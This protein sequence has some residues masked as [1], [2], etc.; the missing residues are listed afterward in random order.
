[1]RK[2]KEIWG[3]VIQ[4][5]ENRLSRAEIE[6]WFSNARL[7]EAGPSM[8]TIEVPNKFVANWLREKY[9]SELQ[10]G[11]RI[12]FEPPPEI[13][14]SFDVNP[15]QKSNFSAF[16]SG[17]GKT[18]L[19]WFD[20]NL[21]FESFITGETNRFAY[22]SALEAARM[23]G[24]HYNPLYIWGGPG[25]GKTHLLHA[26]GNYVQINR[27]PERAQY[28]TADHF[29]SL[30]SSARRKRTM[31]HLRKEINRVS[32]LLF[33]DVD[34]LAGRLKT[35]KEL[36]SFFNLFHETNRQIVFTAKL[37]PNQ[38][39]N[40]TEEIAS[41]LHWGVISEI[42]SPDQETKLKIIE[43]KCH[44]EGIDI[45]DDAAFFL[46]SNSS[47][48]KEL[49]R[50]V[51]R[52]HTYSSLHHKPI[53]ISLVNLVISG[54][55]ILSP[56]PNIKKIQE[57]TARFFDLPVSDLLSGSKK[58]QYS[59]PRQIAMYLC[60]RYTDCSYKE[61]GT[62]FHNKDHSTVMYA[63]RRIT[64]EREKNDRTKNDILA[65]ENLIA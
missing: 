64:K 13:R 26:I 17:S 10:E 51:T 25:A 39:E 28:I 37:P 1:M 24:Q 20:K 38:I 35:Q 43:R 14:Y 27:Q 62:A 48:M 41:R 45:P 44:E 3:H 11:F 9:T 58:R 5:L 7:R 54:K 55:H 32:L 4:Y 30:V 15:D 47:D 21:T 63:V 49:M 22:H 6:T 29:T 57:I 34:L 36:S 2:K 12:F 33:D 8:V 42:N 60:R 50:L 53:D 59:Y 46:A 61:I 31:D 23:P 16:S 18:S 56:A 19:P 65:I 52:L 40:L